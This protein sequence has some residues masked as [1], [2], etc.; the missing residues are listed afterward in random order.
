VIFIYRL[1][2]VNMKY[3]WL[4]LLCRLWWS[5]WGWELDIVAERCAR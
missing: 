4:D 1:T 2:E 5:N 3:V